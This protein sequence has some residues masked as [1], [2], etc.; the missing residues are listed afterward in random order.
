MNARVPLEQVEQ[1][2]YASAKKIYPRAVGGLFGRWRW[3]FVFA[4]QLVF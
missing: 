1:S 2:L 4:T 3:G